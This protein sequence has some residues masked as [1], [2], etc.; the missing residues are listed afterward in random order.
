MLLFI[1]CHD[2]QIH[3]SDWRLSWPHQIGLLCTVTGHNTVDSRQLRGW[4]LSVVHSSLQHWRNL[5]ADSDSNREVTMP[6]VTASKKANYSCTGNYIP[7]NVTSIAITHIQA[8]GQTHKWHSGNTVLCTTN[9]IFYKPKGTKFKIS[10]VSRPWCI[11]TVWKEFVKQ[12][13]FESKLL[14]KYPFPQSSTN[15]KIKLS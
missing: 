5:V 12:V 15:S 10:Y 3:L 6:D 9:V 1:P 2:K 8:N 7:S 13:N 11:K 4:V 14:W